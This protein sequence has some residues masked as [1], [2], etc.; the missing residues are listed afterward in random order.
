MTGRMLVDTNILVYA[1][2][3]SDIKKN[4]RSIEILDELR[5]SGAGVLSTQVLMEFV[6][7]VTGNI[8]NPMNMKTAASQARIFIATWPVVPVTGFIV[9]EALRGVMSHRLSLWDA[10]V[11][12]TA[13]MNQIPTVLTEDFAHGIEIDGV[14]FI[15]PFSD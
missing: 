5:N 11:W 10:Q 14:R 2:D 4:H 13:R 12:A 6:R 1:H 7:A 9:D 3:P 15:N 8:P